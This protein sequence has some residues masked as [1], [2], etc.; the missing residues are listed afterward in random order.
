MD[1]TAGKQHK[2]NWNIDKYKSGGHLVSLGSAGQTN[3]Q[4]QSEMDGGGVGRMNEEGGLR[5]VTFA[6]II[7]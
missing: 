7:G 6:I 5:N 3:E 4:R 1:I 2:K